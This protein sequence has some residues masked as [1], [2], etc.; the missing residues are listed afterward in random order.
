M[1]LHQYELSNR[2]MS[3]GGFAYSADASLLSAWRLANRSVYGLNIALANGSTLHAD[4]QRPKLLF[5]AEGQ[6]RYLY[7]GL[8]P[9]GQNAATHT[10]VQ[11]VKSWTP[12]YDDG[13]AV[14]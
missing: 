12:P 2:G 13:R 11:R 4:R 7:N 10:F 3:P 14:P 6:P 8:D 1:V 5:D 9:N